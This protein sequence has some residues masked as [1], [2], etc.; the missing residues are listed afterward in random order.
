MFWYKEVYTEMYT[1][2]KCKIVNDSKVQLF[3]RLKVR[4]KIHTS[5]YLLDLCNNVQDLQ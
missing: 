2:A 3:L 4:Y 5:L 1:Q